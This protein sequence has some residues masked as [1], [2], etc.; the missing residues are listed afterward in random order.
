MSGSVRM[1]IADLNGDLSTQ[2]LPSDNQNLTGANW[3]ELVQI[4]IEDGN[5]VSV[6]GA[7]PICN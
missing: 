7:Y 2:D 6:E 1:V 4:D 3:L 5:P